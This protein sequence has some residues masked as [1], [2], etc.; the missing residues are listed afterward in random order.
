MS[1]S[2]SSTPS[3]TDGSHL[4][5]SVTALRAELQDRESEALVPAAGRIL[6]V[7]DDDAVRRLLAG[8]LS[9]AGYDVRDVASTWEA[10]RALEDDS[11]TLL[12][13]EV[14]MPR[15]TGLELARFVSSEHPSTATLLMSALDDPGI[16]RAA[17]DI[18]ACGFLAKP[19]S[20][21]AVL[22]GVTSALRSRAVGERRA[23]VLTGALAHLEGVAARSRRLEIEAIHRWAEA[24]EYREPGIGRHVRRV[25]RYCGV[26]GRSFGLHLP[27]LELASVLHDVGKAQIPDSILLKP[28]PLTA[29][30][31]LAIETHA[32]IGYEMLRD[33]GSKVLDLAAVIAST[34]HERFDGTGYPR[35][36]AGDGIPLEGRIAAAADVFDAL[37][38]DRAFRAAWSVD[39]TVSW[40]IRE[41][42]SH[43]DPDVIKALLVSID[44]I[45]AIRSELTAE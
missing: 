30:E 41:S 28:A 37:T 21:S 9:Y 18:G 44:E 3:V 14:S 22:V 34:H 31:R 5:E 4:G 36:L 1:A 7:D 32:D 43:F 35:G 33:S 39:S 20:R 26:L 6:V 29:D 38:C 2:E 17:I 19:I 27:S 24:A 10:R 25:S 11:I 13:T 42:G 16:A 45:L 40:M 23:S 15:E 8:I 12:L